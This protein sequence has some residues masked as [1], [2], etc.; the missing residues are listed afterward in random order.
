MASKP[1]LVASV[2]VDP[3]PTHTDQ[4]RDAIASRAQRMDERFPKACDLEA[5]VLVAMAGELRGAAAHLA[6]VQYPEHFREMLRG[7]RTIDLGSGGNK[8]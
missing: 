5:A 6:G 3:Q 1:T 4:V 2:S 7:E 8:R